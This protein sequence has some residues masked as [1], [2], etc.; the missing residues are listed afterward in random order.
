MKFRAKATAFWTARVKATLEWPAVVNVKMRDPHLIPAGL[1]GGRE[2][3]DQVQRRFPNPQ[4]DFLALVREFL[5]GPVR[6]AVVCDHNTQMGW[7]VG[8][9]FDGRLQPA[10]RPHADHQPG[11]VILM[12]RMKAHFCGQCEITSDLSEKKMTIVRPEAI[13]SLL[14]EVGLSG[15]LHYQP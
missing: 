3:N 15:G 1:L 7:T 9:I 2:L 5:H 10:R 12:R 4:A 13:M 14:P 6:E 8:F 11:L